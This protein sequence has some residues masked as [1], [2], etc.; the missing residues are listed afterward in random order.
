MNTASQ[1]MEREREE[2][3]RRIAEK[4]KLLAKRAL[5]INTLQGKNNSNSKGKITEY[6]K[7]ELLWMSVFVVIC[8]LIDMQGIEFFLIQFV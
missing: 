3:K 5:Q 2:S 1:K 8:W 4:D 7:N 6:L